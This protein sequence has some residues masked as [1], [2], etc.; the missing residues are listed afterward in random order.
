MMFKTPIAQ[1]IKLVRT[2]HGL[3][4]KDLAQLIGVHPMSIYYWESGKAE[5][6]AVNKRAIEHKLGLKTF[7]LDYPVKLEV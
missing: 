2:Q 6:R 3:A 7:A 4:A 5:P 1:R